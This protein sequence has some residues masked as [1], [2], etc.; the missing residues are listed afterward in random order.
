MTDEKGTLPEN[1]QKP[2][3]YPTKLLSK[4]TNTAL[5]DVI[6]TVRKLGAVFVEET[7]ALK[8]T[9]HKAFQKLQDQ[10]LVVA[11]EYQN[12]MGQMV[13][14]KNE[15]AYADSALREKLKEAQNTFSEISN[16]N[17]DA[18]SRMQRCTE[19]LGNT[20]RNAAIKAVQKDRGYSYGENGTISKTAKRK[21]V[22][23]G[24]SETV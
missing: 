19:K 5:R 18:I 16:H 9:D 10:K 20:I 7:D 23:S 3:E 24:L 22:S 17:M 4:D 21:A 2:V 14:R 6:T 12:V 1:V 15:L 11:R 8:K 13:A